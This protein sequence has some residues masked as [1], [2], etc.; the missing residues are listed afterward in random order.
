MWKR[1]SAKSEA[2]VGTLCIFSQIQK[3]K[4]TVKAPH[5]S[6]DLTNHHAVW[7]DNAYIPSRPQQL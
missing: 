5:R 7:H 3:P 4:S 6:N 1:K 2:F